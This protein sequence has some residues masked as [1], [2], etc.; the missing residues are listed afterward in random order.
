MNTPCWL[1]V[2]GIGCLSLASQAEGLAASFTVATY[3]VHNYLDPATGNREPK[4]DASRA[5]VHES[6]LALKPDVLAVQEIGS[7]ESLAALRDTLQ[8]AGHG[9]PYWEWVNGFDTNIHVAILS[10]Y[11]I[12]A[13]RSQTNASFLLQGRRFHTSRGLGEVDILVPENYRFT[14][15]TAHFKSRRPVPSADEALL[16]EQEA[17]MLRARVDALLRA[18]PNLNLVVLGDFNDHKNS[19]A[20]RALVGKGN[21]MLVD[22]RPAE[23]NGDNRPNPAAGFWPRN[24][25]W[26][27]FY[28]TDDTYSR[29]DYILI[30]RGMAREWQSEGTY[31]LTMP[32]WGLASDH[33][34]IVVQFRNADR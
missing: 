33:R 5:K 7:V 25:T 32:N 22:T 1:W 31:I 18:D 20:M 2:C 8:A 24:V 3:N 19:P 29:V 23:R 21:A 26:T 16:R 11:R 9:F 34:P 17:I 10:R 13:S 30:S 27:Y 6:I 4:S 14:L 15:L 28:S 12:M